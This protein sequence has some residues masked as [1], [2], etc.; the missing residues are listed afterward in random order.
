VGTANPGKYLYALSGKPELTGDQV[1]DA[2]MAYG[3]EPQRPQAAGVSLELD[4]RG[5]AVFTRVTGA[6]VGRQLAIVLDNVVRSAPV[7]QDKI[8]GGRASITGMAGDEEARILGIVLRAGALPTDLRIIEERTVGPSLGRDSI[9]QGVLSAAIGAGLVVL[10]M[11]IWYRASGML[12]ILALILNIFFLMAALG[13]M[14][15]TLTLPGIAGIVLT[16]GMSVDA[17]VLI[18]ERI[19]EELRAGKTVAGAI[20]AGYA[21]AFSAIFDS[22]LTTLISSVVLFQFGTGPI[23]G[24]AITLMIGLIANLFTAVF[25]TRL[26]YDSILAKRQLKGLSI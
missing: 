16:I 2:Q 5:A 20:D 10:M 15:G 6:N 7:I 24:F 25:C 8:R 22:N 23:R 21:R 13:M 14:R 1:A 12:A 19:R 18:F 9:R 4:K 17:N 3:L 26:V 11:M